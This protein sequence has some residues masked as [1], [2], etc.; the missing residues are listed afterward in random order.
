MGLARTALASSLL[1]CSMGAAA[2]AQTRAALPASND[3]AAARLGESPRHAEWVEIP[4]SPG[5]RDSLMA[6]VV[7]PVTSRPHSPVVVIVHEIFGLTTWVRAVADQAAAAGFIAIAPD[8]LSRVRGG[9]ATTELSRDSA[10]RIIRA[11]DPAERSLGITAAARYAMALPSA[12]GRYA[13]LGFCWG[14]GTA[15]DYAVNGGIAGFSAAV[16]YYGLP[17]IAGR[18]PVRDSL[19]KIRVP[20]M[21]LSGAMDA[22]IGAAM[23][24]VDSMMRALHKGY[25]G[26]NYA[27]AIHG[28][29]RAQN[30]L[31]A[32]QRDPAEEQA[33]LAAARDAWPRTVAFLRKQVGLR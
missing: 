17:Y 24:A 10:T 20:V 30:D 14:G 15:W 2:S 23:P 6:W 9:P 3:S 25:Y 5:S 12:E 21:L 33:N 26:R 22:R 11:V 16:A 4:W 31:M 1:V 29:L 28:F 8:L 7:Y 32:P 27:G 19:A 18:E 13:V